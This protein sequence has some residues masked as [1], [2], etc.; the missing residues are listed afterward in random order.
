MFYTASQKLT[1]KTKQANA[2]YNVEKNITLK[3]EN[4]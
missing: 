2:K 1:G 3:V 4:K